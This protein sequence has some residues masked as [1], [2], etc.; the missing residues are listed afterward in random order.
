MEEGVL[1]EFKFNEE[2]INSRGKWFTW[3][4]RECNSL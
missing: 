3:Y 2:I 1:G 4:E